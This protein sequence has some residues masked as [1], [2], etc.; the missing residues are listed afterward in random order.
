MGDRARR[1]RGALAAQPPLDLDSGYLS[2]LIR[3]LEAD[4]LIRIAASHDPADRRVR[5]VRLTEVGREERE[6]IDARSDELAASLL[7]PLSDK[8]RARPRRS[9]GPTSSAC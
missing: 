2:R 6:L 7:D 3:S 8:Q 5:A 4:R 9:H 1:L